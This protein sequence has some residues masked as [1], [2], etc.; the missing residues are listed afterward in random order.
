MAKNVYKT[1]QGKI[2]NMDTLRLLNEKESAIGNMNV[3]ARGDQIDSDG[4]IIMR[5]SEIMK[6]HYSTIQPGINQQT[7]KK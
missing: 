4:K 6:N 3:N 5:R 1:A 7:R 2:I